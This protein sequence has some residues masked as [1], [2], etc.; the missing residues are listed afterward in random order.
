MLVPMVCKAIPNEFLSPVVIKMALNQ[1]QRRLLKLILMMNVTQMELNVMTLLFT[2]HMKN[3]QQILLFMD[4]KKSRVIPKVSNYYLE[5]IPRFNDRDFKSHFRLS[6]TTCE[7]LLMKIHETTTS[8]PQP[9]RQIDIEKRLLMFL[10]YIGN[11]ESFRS[12]ADRFDVSKG[13]LHVSVKYIS[14]VLVTKIMP[15]VISWP[16]GVRLQKIADGFSETSRLEGTIGAIDGTHIEI[17]CPSKHKQAYFNRKK[18]PSLVLLAVCDS[19]LNFTYV[20]TG[21]PGSTHDAGV[22]RQTPLY[23]DAPGVIPPGKHIIGD[24]A[25]PL[26]AWLMKPFRDNGNLSRD[27]IKFNQVLSSSRQVIERGFGFLKGRFRRL[28]K[29]DAVDMQVIVETILSGCTLH[30]ICLANDD[31][32]FDI[33]HAIGDDDQNGPDQVQGN[34]EGTDVRQTL[35]ERL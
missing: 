31:E 27:Q 9:G 17:K 14:N 26:N 29:L 12:M 8:L 30:N 21:C 34:Q 24:S 1:R 16:T 5:T 15:L 22:L 18:Y 20:F 4:N 6:K 25:F 7:V 10:W 23:R 33:E 32:M 35:M 2:M 13:T 3:A 11:M 28:I 19:S